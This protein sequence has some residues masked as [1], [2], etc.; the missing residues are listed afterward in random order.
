MTFNM[1]LISLQLKTSKK[2]EKNLS[3]LVKYIE[4]SPKN[5]FIL[6]P[7]LYLT[8][9]SYD[10]LEEAV[11][12]T[13]KAIKVLKFLSHEKIIALTMT[14]KQDN[15]YFNTLHIFHKGKIVHTQS[16]AK[17][18]VLNDEKK[19]FTAG[20]EKD[21][22][23]IKIDGLKIATLIC[24][25]LRYIELWKKLQGA[26]IILV[27]A[28][29]GKIRKENYETLTK[30]LAVANQCYVI[31]SDSS[32]NEMAKSSA[33]ISPFGKVVKNDNKKVISSEYD[34]KEIKKMRRYLN[35]GIN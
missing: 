2:F 10:K 4:S 27:P 21:I 35:I 18:F 26:D 9:Y 29:W 16:K 33:I 20:K 13:N 12:I 14:T 3:K 1:N 17:L 24:F 30:A 31:A 22:K 7:E 25:E 34:N 11:I 19:Y 28:M 15:N 32:N 6:A 5:S 23:I 8:G